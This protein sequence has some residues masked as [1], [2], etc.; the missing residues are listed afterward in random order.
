[1][2]GGKTL[3]LSL[4]ISTCKGQIKLG[5]EIFEK[6]LHENDSSSCYFS[7]SSQN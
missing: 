5:F 3:T 1:L 7:S 4:Q 6:F 2:G